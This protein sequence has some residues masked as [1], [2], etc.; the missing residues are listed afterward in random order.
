[1]IRAGPVLTET[2]K[3]KVLSH[4]SQNRNRNRTDTIENPVP[5]KEPKPKFKTAST[6]NEQFHQKIHQICL[7]WANLND[8]HQ[9]E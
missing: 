5:E 3:P 8:F 7:F 1:M 2:E 6:R 4:F 9:K